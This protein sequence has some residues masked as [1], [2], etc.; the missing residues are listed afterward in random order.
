MLWKIENS[1]SLSSVHLPLRSSRLTVFT[2]GSC[3]FPEFHQ[4]ALAGCAAIAVDDWKYNILVQ[5]MMPTPDHTPFRAEVAAILLTLQ[6][7]WSVDFYVACQAAVD[8]LSK[9]LIARAE[10]WSCPVLEHSDLWGMIWCHLLRRPQECITV[11]KVKAHVHPGSLDDS[12]QKWCAFMNNVVDDLANVKNQKTVFA[13]FETQSRIW[14]HQESMLHCYQDYWCSIQERCLATRV[15]NEPSQ[16]QL[17]PPVCV[18]NPIHCEFP[19]DGDVLNSCPFGIEFAQTVRTYLRGLTWFPTGEPV[20]LLEIYLDFSI[21][22][23]M[24]TPVL[25]PTGLK[26]SKGRMIKKYELR[27]RNLLADEQPCDLASQSKVWHAC[28]SWFWKQ[29]GHTPGHIVPKCSSLAKY[30]YSIP[31][32]G[33]SCGVMLYDAVSTQ[34]ALWKAFHTDRGTR[35]NLKGLWRS[36]PTQI[37]EAGGWLFCMLRSDGWVSF[38]RLSSSHC[39]LV[40]H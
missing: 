36:Y 25:L 18:G 26:K 9:L 32:K 38:V 7:T 13:M 29:C 34:Q 31:C 22:Q 6:E 20:S 19:I 40:V 5:T 2:D 37:A 10:G 35:R 21:S 16:P 3:F 11:T 12:N 33:L 23:K 4:T 1:P 28:I 27:H 8:N 15:R 14:K 17:G 30:G 24:M 39:T